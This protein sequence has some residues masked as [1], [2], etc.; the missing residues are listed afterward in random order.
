MTLNSCL[1]FFFSFF[2]FLSFSFGNNTCATN[3]LNR[4]QWIHNAWVEHRL[5]LCVSFDNTCVGRAINQIICTNSKHCSLERDS[6]VSTIER[7]THVLVEN[8]CKHIRN[9]EC[10]QT[11]AE[12]DNENQTKSTRDNSSAFS[13]NLLLLLFRCKCILYT[14][15]P[16]VVRYGQSWLIDS[17]QYN[18]RFKSKNV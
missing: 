7:L 6:T 1:L 8:T 16:T 5:C 15:R 18:K 2:C 14:V 17:S 3:L 13:S 4:I 11:Q 12:P 9:T 10:I